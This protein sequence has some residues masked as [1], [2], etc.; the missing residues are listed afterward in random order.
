MS[1]TQWKRDKNLARNLK[2]MKK[3]GFLSRTG[4]VIRDYFSRYTSQKA[5]ILHEHV[6]SDF[7]GGLN[8]KFFARVAPFP[9]NRKKRSKIHNF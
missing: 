7:R 4:R 1:H 6:K 5:E 9:L 8:L 3:G 2:K